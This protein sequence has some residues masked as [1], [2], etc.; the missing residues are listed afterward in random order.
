MDRVRALDDRL[1]ELV[2]V[3]IKKGRRNADL[4]DLTGIPA[5]AW[6]SWWA[7]RARPSADM[8]SAICG[9]WP[10]YALW[11]MTGVED[12]IGGQLSPTTPLEEQQEAARRH[13]RRRTEL[14]T[15]KTGWKQEGGGGDFS[16]W[17]IDELQA[18]SE[19]RMRELKRRLQNVDKTN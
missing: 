11:L 1:R 15:S 3:T 9:Q 13:L 18:L 17:E 10:E 8:L 5:S 4:E 2:E 12:P 6:A 16:D 7:G 14:V 19:V